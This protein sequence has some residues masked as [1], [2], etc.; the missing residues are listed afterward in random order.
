MDQ[1]V[2]PAGQGAVP[3][4]VK[5]IA[6]LLY[7][8]SVGFI[9]G[10]IL[11]FLL[12]GAFFLE[13]FLP[14]LGGLGIGAAVVVLLLGILYFFAARGLWHGKSWARTFTIVLTV[15]LILLNIFDLFS[16]RGVNYLGLI[17]NMIILVYLLIISHSVKVAFSKN[18]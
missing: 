15:I 16:G 8:G 17:V 9:V 1:S 7:L 12:G 5:I 14:F 4:G 10:G 2:A 18:S 13:G 11:M 3:T 6:V